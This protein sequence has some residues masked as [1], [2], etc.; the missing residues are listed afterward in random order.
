MK[1]L[2]FCMGY[3]GSWRVLVVG[4]PFLVIFDRHPPLWATPQLQPLLAHT[5]VV[6]HSCCLIA[7]RR[8]GLLSSFCLRLQLHWM[9]EK[10]ATPSWWQRLLLG[11]QKDRWLTHL[12][13]TGKKKDVTSLR[14]WQQ[15]F[16]IW[17]RQL[18]R[19]T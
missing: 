2:T 11:R 18:L 5:P 13:A 14:R 9:S 10:R 1:G 12:G 8:W 16:W 6:W 3:R 19:Q 15:P 17:R 4:V 7:L